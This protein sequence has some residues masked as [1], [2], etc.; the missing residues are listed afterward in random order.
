MVITAFPVFFPAVILFDPFAFPDTFTT[1]VLLDF[2]EATE[3]P[4]ARPVALKA[5]VFC[6]IFNGKL[7]ALT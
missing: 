4:F 3:S 5:V 6:L 7:V 1:F 2:Q